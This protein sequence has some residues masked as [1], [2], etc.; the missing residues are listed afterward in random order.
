MH[1]GR[2]FCSLLLF[3]ITLSSSAFAYEEAIIRGPLR[4][5]RL[6]A[7]GPQNEGIVNTLRVAE[8]SIV[9]AG[10]VILELNDDVAQAR[11][12]LARAAA[13]A[14]GD[15][16]QARLHH[17]EAQEVLARTQQAS[18]RGAATEWEVRQARVRVEITKAAVE[19]AEER[20]NVENQR[21][22]LELA[23]A[24]QSLI[25]APFDG[26]V[27]RVDTVVGAF[28]TRGDRPVTIADLTVLEAALF[29][30]AELWFQLRVGNSYPLSVSEPIGRKTEGLLRHMDPVMD[31]ASGRFRAVFTI[32]NAD[33][34]IPAGLDVGLNLEDL[35]P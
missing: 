21:L 5:V 29:L 23:Q 24:S 16:R 32:N 7:L 10:S 33:L 18:T 9:T 31:A 15:L 19:S 11:V 30:P 8:G 3:A 26:M 4:P 34:Q 2:A 22:N 27:T 35:P 6:V 12:G 14:E 25:R 28:V 17:Q 1:L 13:N 20:R